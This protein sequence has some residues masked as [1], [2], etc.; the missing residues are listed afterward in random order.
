MCHSD[1]LK[2][3]TEGYCPSGQ[4]RELNRRLESVIGD[5]CEAAPR[6]KSIAA[7]CA[8]Y[9]G[10]DERPSRNSAHGLQQFLFGDHAVGVVNQEEK[11]VE[12]FRSQRNG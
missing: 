11:N 1:Y 6:G 4:S 12:S 3:F 10:G 8:T 7:G 5:G 9:A 2:F